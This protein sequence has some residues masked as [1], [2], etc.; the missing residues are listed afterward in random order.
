MFAGFPEEVNE[1]S[2]GKRVRTGE[3][4]RGQAVL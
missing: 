3:S 4:L 1:V 2:R